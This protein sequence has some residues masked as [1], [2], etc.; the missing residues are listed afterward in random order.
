[1]DKISKEII[2]IKEKYIFLNKEF[3]KNV[4]NIKSLEKELTM[5]IIKN[6]NIKSHQKIILNTINNEISFVFN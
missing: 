6:D 5:L 4:F 1:M 3:E 2:I